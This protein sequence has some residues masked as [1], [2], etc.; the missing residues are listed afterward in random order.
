MS[1]LWPCISNSLCC[2]S[3]YLQFSTLYVAFLDGRMDGWM[4]ITTLICQLYNLIFV[5]YI[6]GN[7]HLFKL[8]MTIFFSLCISILSSWETGCMRKCWWRG[9]AAEMRPTNFIR[10]GWSTRPSWLSWLKIRNGWIKLKRWVLPEFSDNSHG[11]CHHVFWLPTG[12]N[13]PDSSIW[14]LRK[15]S[16]EVLQIWYGCLTCN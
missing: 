5:C 1:L 13:V 10:N 4:G 15:A 9:T 8:N 3:V 6:N 16:R 14:Y 7:Q 11:Q 12:P 2:W